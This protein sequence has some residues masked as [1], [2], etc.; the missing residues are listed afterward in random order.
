MIE[1]LRDGDYEVSCDYCSE[2]TE[3]SADSWQD[4]IELI[5]SRGWHI[6]KVGNDWKHMCED[7]FHKHVQW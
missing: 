5:K 3:V 6:R 7:C 2:D 1:D 4:M